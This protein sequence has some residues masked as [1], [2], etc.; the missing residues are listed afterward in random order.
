MSISNRRL[1]QRVLLIEL[2]K[3]G[4]LRPHL[5]LFGLGAMSD[6]GPQMRPKRTLK[7]AGS[8]PESHPRS[9]PHIGTSEALHGIASLHGGLRHV[10]A[11]RHNDTA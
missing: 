6:L 10:L 11:V 9:A 3:I 5:A 1:S 4:S 7:T 2:L 8:R